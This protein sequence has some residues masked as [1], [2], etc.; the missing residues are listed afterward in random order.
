M[1]SHMSAGVVAKYAAEGYRACA[2]AIIFNPTFSHVLICR[3]NV[4]ESES[5]QFV[6]V[7]S[8]ASGSTLIH[9]TV[10]LAP[11]VAV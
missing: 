7:L 3:R 9:C 11:C 1:A 6:Q 4:A 10:L 5:W 2:G 8:C